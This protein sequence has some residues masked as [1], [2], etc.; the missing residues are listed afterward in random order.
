M[1]FFTSRAGRGQTAPAAVVE[2]LRGKSWWIERQGA[3]ASLDG[4]CGLLALVLMAFGN[5]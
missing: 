3:H 2:S 4:M 1:K 5:F